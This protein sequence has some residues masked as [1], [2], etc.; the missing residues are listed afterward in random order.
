[1]YACDMNF[2]IGA[3]GALF[4]FGFITMWMMLPTQTFHSLTHMSPSFDVWLR[5]NSLRHSWSAQLYPTNFLCKKML[6]FPFLESYDVTQVTVV[7]ILSY[8]VTQVTVVII[9]I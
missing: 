3:T 8:D 7:I 5:Y 2:V 1:M 6:F 9:L 4:S